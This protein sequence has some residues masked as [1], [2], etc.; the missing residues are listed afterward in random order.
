MSGCMF[1]AID[2]SKVIE[3]AVETN[4]NK[5]EIIRDIADE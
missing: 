2:D 4:G 5:V 3:Y 1:C